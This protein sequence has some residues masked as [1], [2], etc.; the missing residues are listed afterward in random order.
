VTEYFEN[1]IN[2]LQGKTTKIYLI[3]AN[4]IL[5]IFAIWFSNI[6]L[7]PFANVSDFLVFAGLGLLLA[8]YRP[9]WTFVLFIGSL[10][11]ENIN[12]APSVFGLSLRP[13]QF[14]GAITIIALIMRLAAKRLPLPAGE[15]FPKFKWFDALPIIFTI[16][17]FLS[18]LVFGAGFKQ[19]IV[20]LSFVALYFLT[21]IYIQSFD[22]LKRI[23]PFFLS[24]GFVVALYGI[25]Q[26]ILFISG[27]NA[28]EAMPGRP[29]GTFSEPDWFGIFLVFVLAIIFS[30][31]YHFKNTKYEIRDTKYFL[32]VASCWLL[33]TIAFIALILTVSRSAWLGAVFVTIVFLKIMLTNASFGLSNWDWKKFLYSLGGMATVIIISIG[34]VYIFSLSRF[35]IGSR[36]ASTGG[37]QKITIACQSESVKTVPEKINNIE[38]LAEYGC[39]HINL[40][41]I[42]QEKNAGNIVQ[43][44]YRPDPNIN[45][46]ADIYR[47]SWEQIKQHPVFG[48]GWGTISQIL[49]TDE[50]GAGL[51]ASNIFLE[52]WLGSGLLGILS[53]AILLIYIFIKVALEL[54][55]E[56][57]ED[58][59][60]AL[61]LMLGFVAIIVPNLFNSGIFLGF[62]WVFLAIANGLINTKNNC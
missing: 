55:R 46:R 45:I 28:F 33:I 23:L 38:E 35:Q 59:T 44:I 34:S 50:R 20:A 17:G 43:E 21:R 56:K 39:R 32:L 40:E 60:I 9:G 52:T 61:F 8:I 29:N 30:I 5:V 36:A 11:L 2:N 26:N 49:G 41:E 18:S 31:I 62:V 12:L 4:I 57:T 19:A 37:L 14:L 10:A 1:F 53:F 47:K 22:D 6:G 48:I 24:S 51:N 3:L 13:Y 27:R 16:G 15:F 58:K 54:L 7:L 25:L 42:E